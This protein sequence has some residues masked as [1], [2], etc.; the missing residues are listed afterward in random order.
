MS[1]Y[2]GRMGEAGRMQAAVPKVPALHRD[3]F[4]GK[5]G[6]LHLRGVVVNVDLYD[7]ADSQGN[8]PS[9]VY[10]DVLIYSGLRGVRPCALAKRVMVLEPYAGMGEGSTRRPRACT[11]PAGITELDDLAGYNLADLDG[12]HVALGFFDQDVSIPFVLGFLRHPKAPAV[13]KPASGDG[14][15]WLEVRNGATV[16]VDAAGAYVIDLTVSH[17]GSQP[18][19]SPPGGG[20]V[21]IKLTGAHTLTIEV[22][23]APCLVVAGGGAAASATVGNGAQALA[24]STPLAALWAQLVAACAGATPPIT[25]PPFPGSIASTKL[26]I[27]G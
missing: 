4:D 3:M 13:L 23:G 8:L 6:A 2:E 9:Q 22:D 14:R 21:T 15:P 11:M 26:K 16:G 25:V 18:A 1:K 19:P 5:Q 10:V 12:D 24:M 17:D 7:T 20:P 27:P